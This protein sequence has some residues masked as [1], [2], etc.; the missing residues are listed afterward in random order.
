MTRRQ[1]TQN[2]KTRGF[3][4]GLL[5][6]FLRNH[7][8]A[9]AMMFAVSLPAGM[10][11]VG[12]ASDFAIYNMKLAKLQA[13]ADQAAIAGAKE[14]ALSTST[15]ASVNEAA[16]SFAQ[17]SYSPGA[18]LGVSVAVDSKNASVKVDL[19]ETWS[20][21]FAHFVGAS[22]TPVVAK[23][24]ASLTGQSNICVLALNPALPF[25]LLVEASGRIT[26][27][28]CGLYSDSKHASGVTVQSGG[29]IKADVT[30]S[31]GGV[32]NSGTITPAA[33]TDCPPVD[34]PLGSRPAPP[35][36]A[37]LF[38]NYK[39][40][41]G[42]ATLNPGTYCGG[43]SIT[44]TAK[45]TFN[46]GTYVLKNGEFKVDNSAVAIGDHVGFFLTGL[47]S[48]L[49]FTGSSTISFTG[50]TSGEMSGLLFYEDRGSALY[51]VHRINSANANKLTGTIYLPK[52][53]LLIDP[54]TK[55]ADQSAYTAI[56]AQGV[57]VSA[58]PELVL[59]SDYGATDVPVPVGIKAESKV[60][61]KQ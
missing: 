55:V 21:F 54:S 17:A 48:K 5:R 61:L 39:I 52:G 49:N 12:I 13:A 7:S 22:V 36:G 26:A 35:V 25:M 51:R 42:T 40:T 29:A 19:T 43:I 38:T 44:G 60:V 9:T 31:A 16:K 8:G 37:C 11:A 2:L 24:T 18:T 32:N 27:N 3:R 28:S 10:G 33:T 59:N 50:A 58:G 34:D 56:I 57:K 46:P 53:Y 45:V 4:K 6:R 23:A 30:C 20:P 15:T 1:N 47:T 41:T 14:F